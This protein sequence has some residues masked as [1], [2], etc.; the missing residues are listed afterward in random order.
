MGRIAKLDPRVTDLSQALEEFLLFKQADGAAPR[1]LKDYTY[2]VNAFLKQ[3]PKRYDYSALQKAVLAYFARP[4]SPATRNMACATSEPSS[5]G[6]WPR[7]TS[8]PT[9]RRA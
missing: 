1:T 8:P 3:C 2:H 4:V 6:A 9:P 7:A 5:T